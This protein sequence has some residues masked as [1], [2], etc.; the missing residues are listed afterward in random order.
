[1]LNA[2][3]VV[4]NLPS[5]KSNNKQQAA[6]APA[7]A[8]DILFNNRWGAYLRKQQATPTWYMPKNPHPANDRFIMIV[9]L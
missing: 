3:N 8:P 7:E 4:K 6:I 2:I 1:M 9:I 5:G